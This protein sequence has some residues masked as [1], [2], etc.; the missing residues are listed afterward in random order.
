MTEDK[1]KL[2][3]V[4]DWRLETIWRLK[5]KDTTKQDFGWLMQPCMNWYCVYD[6]Y[7]LMCESI[8]VWM[9]NCMNVWMWLVWMYSLYMIDELDGKDMTGEVGSGPTSQ[10]KHSTN[11]LGDDI[12]VNKWSLWRG[13]TRHRVAT[14]ASW[15]E[16]PSF[17]Q[18]SERSRHL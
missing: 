18:K 13:N 3:I 2:S 12:I 17:N 10:Y 8:N 16:N 4:Q 15:G 14:D 7:A 6:V 1:L 5:R 9:Y 11:F